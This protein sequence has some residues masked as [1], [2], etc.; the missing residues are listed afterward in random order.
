VEHEVSGTV[1]GTVKRV[2]GTV[3]RVSGTV[4]LGVEHAVSEE[5]VEKERGKCLGQSKT[6]GDRKRAEE[7]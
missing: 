2:S 1:S 3:K 7:E 6:G 4:R 5:S